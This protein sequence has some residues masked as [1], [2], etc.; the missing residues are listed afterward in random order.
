MPEGVSPASLILMKIMMEI[1]HDYMD[2]LI[3]IHDNIL[4]LATD[5]QDAYQKLVLIIRRCKER[6]L[7][8]KLSKSRF[9]I[10]TVD[11]FGYVCSENSYHLS[12]E[13]VERI[14]AIPFP[15][16]AKSMQGLRCILSLSSTIIRRR[17]A[18]STI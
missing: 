7:Y 17:P 12:Q 6:N 15:E 13:R 5:Y 1:F 8:L 11:F 14:A 4:L 2:W 10:R 16:N 18:A 9:G 3:V